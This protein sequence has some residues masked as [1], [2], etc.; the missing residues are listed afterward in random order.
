MLAFMYSM[1]YFLSDFNDTLFTQHFFEKK[2]LK[3][4]VSCKSILWEPSCSIRTDGQAEGRSDMTLL[5]AFCNF[6]YVPNKVF[7]T[8]ESFMD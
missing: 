5:F 2:I 4:E 8:T 7:V 3:Y 6:A 1:R